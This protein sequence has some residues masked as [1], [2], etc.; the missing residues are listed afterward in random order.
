MDGPHTGIVV[1]FCASLFHPDDGLLRHISHMIMHHVYKLFRADGQDSGDVHFRGRGGSRQLR[2]GDVGAGHLEGSGLTACGRAGAAPGNASAAAH[3]A[4]PFTHGRGPALLR[5]LQGSAGGGAR[6]RVRDPLAQ[7]R[8]LWPAADLRA[9]LVR[10]PASGAAVVHL[11][12]REPAGAAGHRA[13]GPDG[14]PGGGRLRHGG[15]DRRPDR[16]RAHQPAA[17]HHPAHPVR[18]PHLS[19][20]PR[21]PE[22][23]EGSGPPSGHRLQLFGPCRGMELRGPGRARDGSERNPTVRQQR[24]HLPACGA[25]SPR[26]RAAAGLHDP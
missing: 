15:A 18:H 11:P 5:A 19:G 1:R 12:V 26:H 25:G 4:T 20:T 23:A 3:H 24:R 13:V 17:G 9:V 7:R 16:F 10:H 2:E 21:H 8:G 6:G 22:G 14:G